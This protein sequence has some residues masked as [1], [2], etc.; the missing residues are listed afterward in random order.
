MFTSNDY[1]RGKKGFLLHL[2]MMLLILVVM[3]IVFAVMLSLRLRLWGG[4]VLLA[5]S[6]AAYFYSMMIFVPW[7]KY[8]KLVKDM[9][10]G[11]SRVC[12]VQFVS[13]SKDARMVDGVEV[14]DFIVCEEGRDVEV[15]YLWDADKPVPEIYE[16][17][18]KLRI[19]SFGK[20]IK[21][22]EIV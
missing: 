6:W 7:L 4:V 9:Q 14:N 18:Q 15:L 16:K 21:N 2:G 11:L 12:D 20:Y 22:I 8:Y 17:G 5:G 1:I 3:V 10:E 13:V 19:E